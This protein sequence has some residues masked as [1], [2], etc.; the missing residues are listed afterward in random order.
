[1]ALV[2]RNHPALWVA[3]AKLGFIHAQLDE[4]RWTPWWQWNASGIV[5]IVPPIEGTAVYSPSSRVKLLNPMLANVIQ[6]FAKLEVSGIVPLYTFGKIEAARKAA[7]A[8]V[9]VNEWDL[10]KVKQ[11]ARWD[12]RRAY[13]GLLLARNAK[14]ILDEV[15]S[16]LDHAIELLKSKIEDGDPLVTEGDQFR[17]EV[18]RE[19]ISAR[20]GE[21]PKGEA[22]ALSSLRFL[23]GVQ[24][25][26]DIPNEVLR[27][28]EKHLSSVTTYLLAARLHRPE[29]N[30][31]RTGVLARKY[32]LNFNRAKLFPDLGLALGVSYSVAPSAIVQT[33]PWINDPLNGFGFGVGLG[34]KWN[35]DL[36]PQ[37]A[38]VAQ[39]QSQLEETRAQARMVLGGLSAE[40]EQAYASALEAKNREVAWERA[41]QKSKQWIVVIQEA[42]DMGIEKERA[43][44]DPLRAYV[45]ARITHLQALLDYNNALSYLALV[46]GWD[47]AAP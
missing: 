29:I 38:R 25:D 31:V 45:Q 39:A 27:R 1:M 7:E 14:L 16:R 22:T 11:Q 37:A 8:N 42:V 34:F 4:A 46:S 6:P 9:R 35:L 44:L 41:E 2:E 13:F 36:F 17:L 24:T 23:T 12:V 19:E 21:I 3:R 47:G 30:M 10:E 40:V 18:Y 32:W 5:S 15:L 28:P 26:F 43:L 33:N 20:A